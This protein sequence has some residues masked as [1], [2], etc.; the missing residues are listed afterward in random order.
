MPHRL[1]RAPEHDRTQSLGW[2]A[3]WWIET[4]VQHGR[5][6]A[7]GTPVRYGDETTGFIVD[8]YTL[9][10][11]GQR[12]YDS[13]FLSRPKGTD[14]SGIAAALVLFE[15]FGPCRFG[16][17]A[18]GGETYEFLGQTYV[19]QPGELM[20][21]EIRSPVVKIMATEEGQTGNVYDNVYFNLTD[22]DAPLYQ[23]TTGYGVDVGKT[24]VLIPHNGGSI[25][26]TTAGAA[27]KDGGLETFA[28]FDET[29]IYVTPVLRS[30]YDTV[31]RNLSKRRAE[32]TWFIETTTMYAPGEDSVAEATYKLADAIQEG[33]ARRIRLLFD[34]K[35]AQVE[36]LDKIRV[37]DKE[38]RGGSRLETEEEYETRL[39][40]AFIE[41]FGDAI[42]WN[43]PEH[44]LNDLFDPRRSVSDTLRYF[45]N[46]VVAGKNQWM[47]PALW[48]RQGLSELRKAAKLEG[49][50]FK[51]RPPAKGDE[52]AL[53]FDGGLSDDATVLIACRIDDGLVWPIGVWEA[54][55]TSAAKNWEVDHAEVDAVVRDTFKRFKVKA[56]L[57]D[58][59]FWQDYVDNW[60]K[61]LGGEVE[62]QA[63]QTRP[64]AF[65]TSRHTEMAKAVE[66]TATAFHTGAVWHAERPILTRHV[67]NATVWHR[68]AGDVIG[69]D[70]HG[71]AKKMDAAVGMCLAVEG[72]AR[73][74]AKKKD[75][76]T[77]LVVRVR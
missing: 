10:A 31:V 74:L 35:W 24:R 38:A 48:A 47:N 39:K 69:K 13:A 40:E 16:G 45:F 5:G 68:P 32:G 49:R 21:K 52:I 71:S 65:Y 58:P 75:K 67:L 37:K 20:G 19:Y 11:F 36:T 60:E 26:P 15:A 62:V 33:K 22:E 34:H 6:G 55:D 54:P 63:S 30:M 46:A 59:P 1:I 8:C 56:F 41:A 72:R 7:R 61:D 70:R 17:I 66:R 27:S 18:K 76:Q 57:A 53:A 3:V 43:N 51:Y 12:L 50:E 14:K 28:V 64:F 4:F 73:Y 77:A 25:T 42:A 9:D 44:L 23:L 29:H 2:L